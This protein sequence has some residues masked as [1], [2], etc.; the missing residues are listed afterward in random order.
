[1]SSPWPSSKR[2]TT[3]I[4]SFLLDGGAEDQFPE[5]EQRNPGVDKLGKIQK[6]PLGCDMM[7]SYK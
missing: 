3:L 7:D 4:Q 1:M 2:K 6:F 5:S